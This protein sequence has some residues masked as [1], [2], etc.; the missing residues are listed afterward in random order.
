M[1][2]LIGWLIIAAFAVICAVL[3]LAA[4]GIIVWLLAMVASV[5]FAAAATGAGVFVILVRYF[6]VALVFFGLYLWLASSNDKHKS[7]APV[8]TP[9]PAAETPAALPPSP[10][11]A[12]HLKPDLT[13]DSSAQS[14]E[15]VLEELRA[16]AHEESIRETTH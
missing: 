7:P 9:P 11:L 15:D 3:A 10:L 16:E 1:G 5:V 2:E 12:G 4:I 14:Y 13:G 6:G 8:A